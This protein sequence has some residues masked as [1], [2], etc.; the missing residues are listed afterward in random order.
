[1]QGLGQAGR[2][3]RQ[4]PLQTAAGGATGP[5]GELIGVG[6]GN[7]GTELID[8]GQQGT[9][10]GQSPL[11]ITAGATAGHACLLKLSAAAH[12]S[13]LRGLQRPSF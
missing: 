11:Q 13:H 10:R 4:N 9:V 8:L 6:G 3:H 2:F 7:P 12:F 1:V 5:A